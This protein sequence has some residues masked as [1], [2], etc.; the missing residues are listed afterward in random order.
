MFSMANVFFNNT[1]DIVHHGP[2]Q[3]PNHC[4]HL[5]PPY[6]SLPT[7]FK[8]RKK[9]FEQ[10]YTNYCLHYNCY[11]ALVGEC[12]VAFGHTELLCAS[13]AGG[14]HFTELNREGTPIEKIKFY[15]M[16]SNSK[17]AGKSSKTF[18]SRTVMFI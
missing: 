3:M 11:L 8:I 10:A 2:R 7:T 18:R 6:F 4:Q 9:F 13:G 1:M 15:S 16:L 5:D 17:T 12:H 14:V